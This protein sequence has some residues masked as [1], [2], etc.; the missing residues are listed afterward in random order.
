MTSS[1]K[2]STAVRDFAFAEFFLGLA[3]AAQIA[4]AAFGISDLLGLDTVP[5]LIIRVVVVTA[6][7]VVFVRFAGRRS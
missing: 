7:V 4:A 5:A 1:T 6:G 3:F 2:P